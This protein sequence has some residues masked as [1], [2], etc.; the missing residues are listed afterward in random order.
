[1]KIWSVE[2]GNNVAR[3]QVVASNY[4]EAGKKGMKGFKLSCSQKEIR[5]LKELGEMFIS[6][7]RLVNET[8][9]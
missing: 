1:M 4:I 7:V 6:S 5:D 9:E 2:I 3:R 8:E